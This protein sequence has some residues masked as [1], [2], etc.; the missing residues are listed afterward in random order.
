MDYSTPGF[1]VLH[2]PL[3]L[4]Q[5]HVHWVNEA[6]Q[7][8]HPLPSPSPPAGNLSQH[9]DLFPIGRLF[10]SGDQSTGA[11]ASARPMNIQDWF[12]LGLT[13]WISFQSKGLSRVFSNTTVQKHQFFSS[14][15]SLWS[16]SHIHTW[17]LEKPKLWLNR[18]LL[19]NILS[20]LVIAFLPKNKYLLISWLQSPFAVV[21]ESKKIKSITVSIVFLSICHE[22]MGLDAMILVFWML[23]SKSAFS[24]SPFMFIKRIFSSSFSAIRVVSSAY[25]MLLMFLPA[26][27]IPACASSSLAFCMMYFASTLNKQGDNIYPWC[28][29]FLICNQF[30][31]P[32]LIL[33]VASWPTCRF[34]RRDIEI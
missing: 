3:E 31:V 13:G 12:P 32:C 6:I 24:L 10:A 11:S 34:L 17:I 25:L 5:T 19:F 22:E 26:I 29:P 21:L 15:P 27:L 4:A 18:S 20:M 30:V 23:S 2:H 7:T 14:Q 28:T 33:S 16:S 9:Q 1:P 8:S